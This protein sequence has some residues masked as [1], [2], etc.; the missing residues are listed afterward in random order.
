MKKILLLTLALSW[1][2]VAL[3]APIKETSAPEPKWYQLDL[4]VFRYLDNHDQ[5]A[6]PLVAQHKLPNRA[7]A[8]KN[9]NPAQPQQIPPVQDDNMSLSSAEPLLSEPPIKMPDIARDAFIN[10]PAS[11]FIL[12][13]EAS[14]LAN[15][16]RYQVLSQMA[17]RMPLDDKIKEQPIKVMASSTEGT[18]FLLSGTVTA[19][20]SR[21]LHVD[22]DLWFNELTPEAPLEA[23]P[24]SKTLKSKEN[25]EDNI[26]TTPVVRVNLEDKVFQVSRNFQLDEKRRV[27]HSKEIQYLDSPVIGVLFKLTPYERPELA[28]EV[29]E[30]LPSLPSEKKTAAP[31]SL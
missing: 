12:T 15:S 9:P 14:R 31:I 5:E 17:W 22:T 11:E 4:V 25:L 6:W 18:P 7:M 16:S 13:K 19:S 29:K 3:A 2:Q 30:E 26:P 27:K 1:G 21:Y 10:L 23:L 28:S 20:A 24:Q 8:L